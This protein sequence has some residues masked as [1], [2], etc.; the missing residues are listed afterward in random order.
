VWEKLDVEIAPYHW[1]DRAR[2]QQDYQYLQ[3]LHETLL[4]ELAVKLNHLHGVKHSLRYWRILIGPWLGYFIQMLF[5]RW[6]MLKLAIEECKIDRCRVLSTK[7]CAVIPNDMAH[8]NQLYTEDDWNEIIYGQLLKQYWRNEIGIEEVKRDGDL[9]LEFGKEA[10][11]TLRTRLKK[12]VHCAV[13]L[14]NR[15]TTRS[16]DFFFISSCLPLRTDFKLQIKLGQFPKLWRSESVPELK[17]DLKIRQWEWKPRQGTDEFSVVARDF[18]PRH[19]PTAYL[20]GYQPLADRVHSLPWPKRPKVIFTSTGYSSADVF[21]AWAA[22]KTESSTPLVIG[23][24][25]GHFGMTPWAFHE[26]HQITIADA[27]LSWGWSDRTNSRVMPV[28]NLKIMG[29]NMDFDQEGD[30]LLVEMALPR[31]SYHM[32]SLPVAG[33]WLAYFEDQGRFIS[34][35]PDKIRQSVLVRQF[36]QDFGWQQ[37]ARWHGSFPSIK[38]DSG[39]Q[40][41]RALI[42]KSRI[43]ICTYNGTTYLESLG[44]NIPT[45]MFW[46]PAHWELRDDVIPYFDLLK[47]V[48]IFHET[49]ESAARQMIT[50]WDDVSSWWWSQA[51]QEVR[52]KFCERYSRLP[53]KPLAVLESV[54][55]K[56]VSSKKSG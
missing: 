3:S 22:E 38:I 41:I 19:I 8:F 40:S 13:D 5:D 12:F 28:G 16:D 35:L 37:E 26:E 32:Y 14:A 47:K 21:K 10:P 36:P 25:G 30:V 29:Q 7:P 15:V 6:T 9:P 4:E 17:P 34:A 55:R 27:W 1:D 2:L 53:D 18:I 52:G 56:A 11:K 33:Q 24:H 46:N 48:G 20:E 50:V 45:I 39:H 23:Q 44:W 51:V 42:R 43:Y 49:P 31:Y 54:F